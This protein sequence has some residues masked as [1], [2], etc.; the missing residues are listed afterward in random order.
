MTRP[1]LFVPVWAFALLGYYRFSWHQSQVYPIWQYSESFLIIL[2]KIMTFT[3]SVG[4]VNIFNQIADVEADEANDGFSVFQ[5]SDLG[6][7]VTIISAVII[8]LVSILIPFIFKWDNIYMFSIAAIVIG[9]LY[10]FKPTYFTGKPIMDFVSNAVGFGVVAFVVGWTLAGGSTDLFIQSSMPYTFLMCAGSISST[11][12][13]IKG[14][15]VGGKLT[16]AVWLGENKSHLLATIF[17]VS[18]LSVSIIFEDNLCSFIC[19]VFFTCISSF[20]LF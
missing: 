4:A 2:V 14:D 19:T 17:I 3:L 5:K 15:K 1:I 13:D 7:W 20:Y 18:A 12:P 9:I 11:L 16:T 10:S 6:I 8:S